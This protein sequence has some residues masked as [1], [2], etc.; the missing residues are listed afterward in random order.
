M[1]A[2][3]NRKIIKAGLAENIKLLI[4]SDMDMDTT[5]DTSNLDVITSTLVFNE[6]SREE[7]RYVLKQCYG[8][9]KVNGSLLIA[10]ETTPHSLL[11]KLLL[12]LFRL[13]FAIIAYIFTQTTTQAV[14]NLD[15]DLK[16]AGFS[17]TKVKSY[18]LGTMK[19]FQ[20]RKVVT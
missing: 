1:L 8:I 16:Q 14:T 20:A 9:L 3:A 4:M 10:D 12:L 5:F 15:I 13:P 19:P 18:L 6:L 11:G 7:I 2:V 17:L